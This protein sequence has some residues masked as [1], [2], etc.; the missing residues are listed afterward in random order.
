MDC[1]DGQ[2][3]LIPREKE[4]KGEKEGKEGK[5][6]EGSEKEGEGKEG[7]SK[8]GESKEGEEG[9]GKSPVGGDKGDKEGKGGKGG[10]ELVPASEHPLY[11]KFFKMLKVGLPMGMVVKEAEAEGLSGSIF[12]D[13]TRLILLTAPTPTPADPTS[14]P[15]APA[16][17]A[18]SEHPQYAK[19]FNMLKV[20]LPLGM[21]K[22]KVKAEGLDVVKRKIHWKATA[23]PVE[24]L[25]GTLWAS[26]EG[27]EEGDVMI[28]EGEFKRLFVQQVEDKKPK[29]DVVKK[30]KK[31]ATKMTLLIDWKRAQNGSI[32]LARIMSRY[33]LPALREKICAMTDYEGL[34]GDQL[35]SLAEYLPTPEEQRIV[36]GFT[37]SQSQLTTGEQYMCCMLDGRVKEWR[38]KV[39]L[40]EGACNDFKLSKRFRKLLIT[41]LKV[42]NELNDGPKQA[43]FAVK[44]LLQLNTAKAF[45]QKTSV[46]QYIIYLFLRSDPDCLLF[47]EDLSH[48]APVSR[49]KMDD[50][51]AEKKGIVNEFTQNN[52]WFFTRRHM[53]VCRLLGTFISQVCADC[54]I[55]KEVPLGPGDVPNPMR[56]DIVVEIG[57]RV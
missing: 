51:V 38:D 32:A 24:E 14:A 15:V 13:G 35:K 34:N 2:A 46:L 5:E 45:D 44:S 12:E 41:I 9:G 25:K 3:L 1:L 21:V 16:Q 56:A 31:N 19:Y 7:E 27:D 28:D 36:R 33:P 4:E 17:V 29:G 30:A 40:I 20:G 26:R 50:V 23:V 11:A 42:G 39:T 6:G 22:D 47:P 37:S 52:T 55:S 49:L 48:I 54:L 53:T 57:A 10:E 43:V 18:V 8:E